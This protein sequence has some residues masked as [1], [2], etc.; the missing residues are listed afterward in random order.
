MV[1]GSCHYGAETNG[2]KDDKDDEDDKESEMRVHGPSYDLQYIYLSFLVSISIYV[3][4]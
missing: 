3:C 2:D 1:R 4:V